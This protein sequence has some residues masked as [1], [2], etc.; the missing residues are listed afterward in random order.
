MKAKK[1][2]KNCPCSRRTYAKKS[3][4]ATFS[5]SCHNKSLCGQ[6]RTAGERKQRWRF[7]T[8]DGGRCSFSPGGIAPSAC[9]AQWL[10]VCEEPLRPQANC[11]AASAQRVCVLVRLR[12]HA[13]GPAR[14]SDRSSAPTTSKPGRSRCV[15]EVTPELLCLDSYT[16]HPQKNLSKISGRRDKCER[17]KQGA[18]LCLENSSLLN[19]TSGKNVFFDSAR[20]FVNL[21]RRRRRFGAFSPPSTAAAD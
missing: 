19:P 10:H 11:C 17:G 9:V 7:H 5:F 8:R 4:R 14:H 3:L 18:C 21:G 15:R 2:K 12:A 13:L 16:T 20:A 1:K 6:L